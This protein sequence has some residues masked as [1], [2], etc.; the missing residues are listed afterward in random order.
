MRVP[1]PNVSVVDLVSVFEKK[2]TADEVNAA[3]EAIVA[4]DPDAMRAQKRLCKLWE[5]A[6]LEASVRT[7]I[8]EF[9]RA[10]EGDAPRRAIA[11][12]RAR[13]GKPP[14]PG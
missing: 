11:E 12:F 7:S 14:R 2:V 6:P 9:A 10:Y 8:D 5:E 3:L 13:R 1:T 4:G